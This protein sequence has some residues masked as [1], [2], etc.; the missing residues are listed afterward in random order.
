MMTAV[1]LT[2]KLFYIQSFTL[3]LFYV[4]ICNNCTIL[5]YSIIFSLIMGVS[6]A[7]VDIVCLPPLAWFDIVWLS[8]LSWLDI[9]WLSPYHG[10]I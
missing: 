5:Y 7:M 9:V 4:C 10:L 2:Y 1:V 3:M 6:L 8:P